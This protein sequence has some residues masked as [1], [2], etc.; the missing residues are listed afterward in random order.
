MS[1]N[2]YQT[3]TVG[4]F[5][6]AVVGTAFVQLGQRMALQG[7]VVGVVTDIAV[8]N[9]LILLFLFSLSFIATHECAEEGYGLYHFVLDLAEAVLI[10]SAYS[11]LGLFTTTKIEAPSLGWF[12][13]CVAAIIGVNQLWSWRMPAESA[14][15]RHLTLRFF[16]V[17]IFAAAGAATLH[18]A[19]TDPR[20]HGAGAV[21]LLL[22]VLWYAR[23]WLPDVSGAQ[24]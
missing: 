18:W 2:R 21:A 22:I 16:G 6:P 20:V 24:R 13:W 7:S 10:F 8:L 1:R 11:L 14:S 19:P 23:G 15:G 9:G 4:L 12:Y 17:G 5:Y 3:L